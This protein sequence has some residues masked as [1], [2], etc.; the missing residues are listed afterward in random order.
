VIILFDAI[1]F[2]PIITSKGTKI[3]YFIIITNYF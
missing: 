2:R 1:R 3:Y